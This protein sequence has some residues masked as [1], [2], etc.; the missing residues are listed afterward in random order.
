MRRLLSAR[1]LAGLLLAGLILPSAAAA[2]PPPDAVAKKDAG[3]KLREAGDFPAAR[4]SYLAALDIAPGWAAA[5]NELGSLAFLESDLPGAIVQFRKAVA[6]EP[7]FALAQY[8]LGFAS[9]KTGDYRAA[10]EAYLAY[11]RLKPEDPDGV[12]GL[13]ESYL[14]VGDRAGAARAYE[15]YAAMEKRESEREYVEKA[16]ARV[17]QL[18]AELAAAVVPATP[19]SAPILHLGAPDPATSAKKM[20]E[21]DAWLR[22]NKA[23]EALF[24]YQDA[25]AA[26]PKSPDAL[27]RVGLAY[28][29]LGYFPEAIQRW[30]KVIDDPTSSAELRQ[31]ARTNLDKAREKLAGKGSSAIPPPTAAAPTTPPSDALVLGKQKY[32]EANALYVQRKYADAIGLYDLALKLRPGWANAHVGRGNA[33]LGAGKAALAKVDFEQATALAPGSAAPLFGLA[34]A[35]ERLGETAKAKALY[36]RYAASTAPDATADLKK[37]AADKAR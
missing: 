10:V 32:D 11:T 37:R 16:L 18:K 15:Q 7:A 6:A 35:S 17:V 14:A 8:N 5:H 12:Y 1:L 33:L 23:R 28:A 20:A 3:D 13:A 26:D 25:V 29:H 34:M 27:F 4:R 9:R 24:A 31:R 2:A 36:G 30:Q 22:Q 21:G 19:A